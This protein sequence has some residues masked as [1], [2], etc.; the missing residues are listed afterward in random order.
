ME[1]TLDL[2]RFMTM[3]TRD[4]ITATVKGPYGSQALSS[5]VSILFP[6]S[7]IP[8]VLVTWYMYPQT[9]ASMLNISAVISASQLVSTCI[10]TI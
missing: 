3:V 2:L 1:H 4:L 9:I 5:K 8:A 7:W 6:N 10:T